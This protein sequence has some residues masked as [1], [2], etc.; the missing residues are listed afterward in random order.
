MS[1]MLAASV[2]IDLHRSNKREMRSN[3]KRSHLRSKYGNGIVAARAI[4][5]SGEGYERLGP[6]RVRVN[7]YLNQTEASRLI[8]KRKD[9]VTPD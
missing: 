9:S 4:A 5:G 1:V 8:V 2:T 3:G 7:P 6:G